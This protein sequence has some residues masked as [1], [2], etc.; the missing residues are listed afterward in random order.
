[1]REVVVTTHLIQ[2]DRPTSAAKIGGGII[3]AS[4]IEAVS[5]ASL[6]ISRIIGGNPFR[7]RFALWEK[8]ENSLRVA[9]YLFKLLYAP[10]LLVEE[11]HLQA[12]VGQGRAFGVVAKHVLISTA[13]AGSLGTMMMAEH[14]Q[15]MAAHADAD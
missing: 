11:Y 6:N 7:E 2:V 4:A 15:E 13:V 12:A 9:R 14:A 10:H 5:G 1:V 8:D 3:P